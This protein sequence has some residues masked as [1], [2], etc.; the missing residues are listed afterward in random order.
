MR[1]DEQEPDMRCDVSGA[2]GHVTIKLSICDW[3]TFYKSGV[4]AMKAQCLTPGDLL[5]VEGSTDELAMVR[6]RITEVSR[7]H[8]T[9][10]LR[11]A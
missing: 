2:S 11:K 7:W 5:C 6:D 1:G 8:S 3:L 4:Y 9:G 10:S